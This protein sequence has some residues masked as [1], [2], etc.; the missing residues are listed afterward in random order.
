MPRFQSR[1]NYW[2]AIIYTLSIKIVFGL[3][4]V[5]RHSSEY[6]EFVKMYLFSKLRQFLLR[7]KF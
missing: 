7:V 5:S 1:I 4:M 6:P 2:V 3:N